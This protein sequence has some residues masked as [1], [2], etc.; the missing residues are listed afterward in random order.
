MDYGEV[1][2]LFDGDNP[3]WTEDLSELAGKDPALLG[4]LLREGLAEKKGEV[5]SLTPSGREAF[6]REAAEC[7]HPAVPGECPAPLGEKERALLRTRLYLLL[8]RKHLQRWGLKE[9]LFSSSFPVPPLAQ[10]ELFSLDGGL[11][12]LWPSSQTV[13]RLRTDFPETGLAARR[14]KAL[15]PG[16]PAAWFQAQGISPEYFEPDFLYLSRYD[17]EAYTDFSSPPDDI[18]GLLNADRF[19]FLQ[20]PPPTKENLAR[21]LGITGRFHLCLEVLRRLVLPG[22]MDFDSHDQGAINWLLFLYEKEADAEGC[23][24]L[25]SPL[26]QEL[27]APVLPTDLWTLS[28]EALAAYPGRA[29]NIH[30]LLP[31]IARPLARAQ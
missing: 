7:F 31:E 25:L 10:D 14:Q 29:E 8:D 28:F 19:F 12:W 2:L 13:K 4:S 22:Y 26:D 15:P 20:G 6:R 24:A 9:Y 11:T 23:S 18:W 1:L 5:Y 27:I 30:D 3:C 21:F 16:T 17:Y